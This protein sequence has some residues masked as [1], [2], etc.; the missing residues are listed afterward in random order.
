M[1][2]EV[3]IDIP[4]ADG[5]L[6]HIATHHQGDFIGE[7]GFL[8]GRPRGDTATAITDVELLVLSRSGLD[9][10]ADNHKRLGVTL[11]TEIARVLASRLRQSN[12]ELRVLES[13]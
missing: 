11:M 12:E 13:A 1:Q 8:D 5:H 4:L 10:L 3:R 2:G 7:L 6:H 9:Q